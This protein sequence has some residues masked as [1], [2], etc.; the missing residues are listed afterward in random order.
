M[1]EHRFIR[2][3]Q[4]LRLKIELPI[5]FLLKLFILVFLEKVRSTY[6]KYKDLKLFQY[7]GHFYIE[8]TSVHFLFMGHK[9]FQY[10]ALK[11]ITFICLAASFVTFFITKEVLNRHYTIIL[12]YKRCSKRDLRKHIF[13]YGKTRTIY[14]FS[15]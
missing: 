13:T 15:H 9:Y 5:L 14:F 4:L 12:I 11:A 2:I 10:K 6:G 7:T 1:F 3:E 8:T